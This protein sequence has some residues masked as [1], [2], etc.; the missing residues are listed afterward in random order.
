M[1]VSNDCKLPTSNEDIHKWETREME[2]NNIN[3]DHKIW[4]Y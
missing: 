2:G 1:N 4:Q 3:A